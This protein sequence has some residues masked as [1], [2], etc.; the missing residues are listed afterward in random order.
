MLRKLFYLTLLIALLVAGCA[1]APLSTGQANIALKDGLNREVKLSAPA[2][3]I[4][5]LAPSITEILF[6]IGA[7]EQIVGRDENSDFPAEVKNIASI[8][9]TYKTL[10]TEAILALKPDLVV[11]ANI[12]TPEQVKALEDLGITVYAFNNPKDFNGMFAHLKI[13]GQLTGHEKEAATLVE[14]L[15][16]RVNAVEKMTASVA[17]HPK[18]FYELDGTDPL[19]PWTSGPGTFID[20]MIKMAGGV[21][22]GGVLSGEW[23][24]ISAEELLLQQPDMIILGDGKFGAT[25]ASIK[26]RAGW[27]DLKAVQNNAVFD[28]NA[29]LASRPAPRLVDGLEALL[30]ILHPE[31]VAV[32]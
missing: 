2:K 11:A 31:L 32:P 26:T 22:I 10:N 19:K 20:S 23:A 27:S 1:P 17:T 25:V 9:S 5:S 6:A 21:N 18:V 28:F 24:Q 15:S 8:G 14:N 7:G 30:G 4:V 29:D 13:A 3:R 16:A 12:N